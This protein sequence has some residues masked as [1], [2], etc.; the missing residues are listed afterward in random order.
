MMEENILDER[1]TAEF[2]HTPSNV[3]FQYSQKSY[4]LPY[5]AVDK[6]GVPYSGIATGLHKIVDWS[7]CFLDGVPHGIFNYCWG[8]RIAGSWEYQN[9]FRV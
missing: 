4:P 2:S 5:Y 7:G 6:N 1:L 8:D 9:G 3:S